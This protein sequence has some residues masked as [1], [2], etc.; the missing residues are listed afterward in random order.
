VSDWMT[1]EDIENRIRE[2]YLFFHQVA[3]EVYPQEQGEL[4]A[5]WALFDYE[6]AK[7]QA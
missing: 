5:L 7:E 6:V 4:G 1:L 2:V 3:P